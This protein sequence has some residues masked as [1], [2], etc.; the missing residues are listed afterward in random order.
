MDGWDEMHV[1][2][3][4]EMKGERKK[5]MRKPKNNTITANE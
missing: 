2:V 3:R 5:E 4:Y 1:C